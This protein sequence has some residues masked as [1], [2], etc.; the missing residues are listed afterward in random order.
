MG[1]GAVLIPARVRS[2]RDRQ[3]GR[4]KQKKKKKK[5]NNNGNNNDD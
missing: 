3:P 5:N 4:R 2:V 1:W